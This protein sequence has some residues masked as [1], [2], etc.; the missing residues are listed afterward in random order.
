MKVLVCLMSLCVRVS[1]CVN[2]FCV[3]VCAFNILSICACECVFVFWVT[4]Y[5]LA[6]SVAKALFVVV[7]EPLHWLSLSHFAVVCVCVFLCVCFCVCFFPLRP[8]PEAAGSVWG[9]ADVLCPAAPCQPPQAAAPAAPHDPRLQQP[10]PPAAQRCHSNTHPGRHL[11][12]IVSEV[13]TH[14]QKHTQTHS[15]I[16]LPQVLKQVFATLLYMYMILTSVHFTTV[17]SITWMV[18]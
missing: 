14:T 8:A 11:N 18:C 13:H 16:P 9:S 6:G 15:R 3:F 17:H 12:L 5:S 1:V 7:F 2:L 4:P 10:H